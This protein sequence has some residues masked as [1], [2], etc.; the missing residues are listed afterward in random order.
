M[1]IARLLTLALMPATFLAN[2]TPA[3][4]QDV[5]DIPMD[6]K[7]AL[8]KTKV[9]VVNQLPVDTLIT[10]LHW[11]GKDESTKQKI[12]WDYCVP[13][14]FTQPVDVQFETSM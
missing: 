8:A 4:L 11:R 3:K 14:D 5:L 10:L 12:E 2:P 13:S 7:L 1:M 9:K 6:N